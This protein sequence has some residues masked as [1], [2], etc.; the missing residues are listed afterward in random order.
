MAF[1]GIYMHLYKSVFFGCEGKKAA[2]CAMRIVRKV[3]EIE[4]KFNGDLAAGRQV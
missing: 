4:D 2:L 1:K 3:D